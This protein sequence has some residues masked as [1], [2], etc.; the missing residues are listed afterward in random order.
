[1][2]LGDK[3]VILGCPL[4][5]EFTVHQGVV[6]NLSQVILGVAYVQTDAKINPG[7]SGG[8]MLDAA[9]RV[10]GIVSLKSTQ[11]D[12]IGWA[13]P[14]NYAWRGDSPFVP[15]PAPDSS[16]WTEMSARADQKNTELA[17]EVASL[18]DKPLLL[19]AHFDGYQ[20]L[21]VR[22]GRASH[23]QPRFEEIVVNV[24]A[25]GDK[26]CTLKGDVAEWQAQEEKQSRK[27][28]GPRTF[29]WLEANSLASAF[30]V[31]ESPLR[32]DQCPSPKT[33]SSI[34]LELEDANPEARRLRLR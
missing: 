19:D 16:G 5:I 30:Y 8:P 14:V 29:A 21:V 7:N 2:H 10:V 33:A 27:E 20:R 31:G 3:V 9:G 26:F 32:F 15:A 11:G 12:G 23:S 6:S 34:E 17:G 13:L 1:L 25:G 28:L 24:Y 22:I 4:G 18:L